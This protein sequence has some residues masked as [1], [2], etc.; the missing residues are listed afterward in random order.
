MASESYFLIPSSE[1]YGGSRADL[2]FGLRRAVR[3]YNEIV[4]PGIAGVRFV[5]QLSW[6]VAALKLR[7][8]LAGS[9]Q[10]FSAMKIAN[11]IEAL[12]CKLSWN[13]DPDA[14]S[15]RGIRAFKNNS[16]DWSFKLLNDRRGY[17][18][19]PYRMSTVRALPEEVGLGFTSGSSFLFNQMYLTQ[20]G[21]KLAEAILE[22]CRVGTGNATLES[23]LIG[24]IRNER[25][26]GKNASFARLHEGLGPDVSTDLEK[27]TV[28]EALKTVAILPRDLTPD[29]DRR[30]LLIDY[31]RGGQKKSLVS[32]LKSK[33]PGH[34]LHINVACAFDAYREA[35]GSFYAVCTSEVAPHNKGLSLQECTDRQSVKASFSDLEISAR[36]YVEAAMG[37]CEHPDAKN[38]ADAVL[39]NGVRGTLERL[40]MMDDRIL[41]LEDGKICQGA[42]FQNMRLPSSEEDDSESEE[43]SEADDLPHYRLRQLH[44]LLADCGIIGGGNE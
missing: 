10:S 7:E 31:F 13:R 14:Y 34:A 3:Y 18:Q 29:P 1:S 4:V 27:D 26:V 20:R 8:R 30:L 43:Q 22:G 42:L 28:R 6:A 2:T 44:D 32:W 35:L 24:W 36:N 16:D 15:R 9:T 19:I 40:V 23:F 41:S 39:N 12:G 33:N 25:Q 5:R 37:V 38:S 21:A 17:V 11:G